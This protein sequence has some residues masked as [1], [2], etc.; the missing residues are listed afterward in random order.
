MA[1]KKKM[2]QAAAGNAGG[3]ALNV[4]DV[5]STYLYTGTGGSLTVN[6]GIDLDGEGGLVWFKN[7][8]TVDIHALFD[9]ERPLT[10]YLRTNGSNAASS[11]TT[12]LTFTSSGFSLN[13]S[14]GLMNSTGNNYAS[15][16]FRKAP[17]FFD[18]VTY[19]G[20]GSAGLSVSHNLGSVPGMI[21]VKQTNASTIW[22]VY[23]RGVNGGTNPE[24]YL[25]YINGTASQIDSD[26]YWNDTA[27]TDS[28]FTVGTNSNVNASG[29]TYVAYLF[30]HNDGDG[31][32]GPSGDQDIIK[33]GSFTTDG[34]GNFSVDLGFEPE[35]FLTKRTDATQNW[36]I[37]DTMRGWTVSGLA[38][39]LVPNA[40]SSELNYFGG[41]DYFHPTASG[42]EGSGN[43]FGT[44]ANVIYM[45][46]R[47]GPLAPP[48]SGT[49][50][51][52][53]DYGGG[54]GFASGFPVDSAWTKN[55]DAAV[56]WKFYDRLRGHGSYLSSNLTVA[57][58][59]ASD[60]NS[61]ASN[62]EFDYG[63]GADNIGYILR[64]AP[65]FFDAVAYTGDGAST[66]DIKHNLGVAPEFIFLKSRNSSS[67]QWP[68]WHSGTPNHSRYLNLTSGGFQTAG[69]LPAYVGQNVTDTTFRVSTDGSA[70]QSNGSS[71]TYIAYLFATLAGVSK[72]GSYTGNGSSQTID[73]GFTSG[74][75]FILIKRT[76]S[77][78]DWYVWDTERGI[79]AGNDPHLS[80]NTTASEV[81]SDDSI[82]PDNSGFIVNQVAAT[83]INVSSA[84]YIFYAIA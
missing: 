34:S 17:K 51:F 23:H 26:T 66:Q 8:Q 5:F 18:V 61:F 41:T 42:V 68:S 2:L 79:V 4:E 44:N 25:L 22:P 27:P 48:E 65:N 38:N 46:I 39:G 54:G 83:N 32:F 78:G 10:D 12:N 35:F 74:A 21:L 62:T 1:T 9:S 40:S 81:T 3:E 49:E 71:N 13:N 57:E 43:F 15:W 33:C 76:D 60:G 77:A 36:Y 28:V 20:T 84:S 30:A 69:G 14:F 6:N 24:N 11:A 16:T 63:L 47:R 7:R 82:D 29:G 80:L 50:V 56:D 19:T 58:A 55:K 37:W 59:S 72:C 31:E 64:R 75:R 45:A 73:C 70:G 67:T 53:M 52:A